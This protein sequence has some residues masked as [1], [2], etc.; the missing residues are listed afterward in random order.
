MRRREGGNETHIRGNMEFGV[1]ERAREGGHHRG[2]VRVVAVQVGGFD[3]QD[4]VFLVVQLDHGEVILPLTATINFNNKTKHVCTAFHKKTTG[5]L[6]QFE[7]NEG[8]VFSSHVTVA[9]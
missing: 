1:G 9:M 7:W 5:L 6:L 8:F 2:F 3:L 4:D